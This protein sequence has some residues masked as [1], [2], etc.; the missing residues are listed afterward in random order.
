MACCR[1]RKL[2]DGG[3]VAELLRAAPATDPAD[4]RR[5][6]GHPGGRALAAASTLRTFGVGTVNQAREISGNP[7]ATVTP[8]GGS[9][10]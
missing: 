9:Q 4:A 2:V 3:R 5:S 1:G 10:P 6:R 8:N 7:S